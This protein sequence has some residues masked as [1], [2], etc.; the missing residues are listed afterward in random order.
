M[1]D[2]TLLVVFV[3]ELRKIEWRETFRCNSSRVNLSADLLDCWRRRVRRRR[4]LAGASGDAGLLLGCRVSVHNASADWALQL[5]ARTNFYTSVE[6]FLSWSVRDSGFLGS[7]ESHC[8][9]FS[10]VSMVFCVEWVTQS[11]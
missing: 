8:V 4:G 6:D 5:Q 2:H 1:T 9:V 11:G 10:Q 7:S 3:T